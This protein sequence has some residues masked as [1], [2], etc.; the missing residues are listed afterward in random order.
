MTI[1]II[2]LLSFIARIYGFNPKI[3]CDP[4]KVFKQYAGNNLIE[5]EMRDTS[6]FKVKAVDRVIEGI[7][8][9]KPLF[10]I[11]AKQARSKMVERGSQIGVNWSTYRED[12]ESNMDKLM[13]DYDHLNQPNL[14]YPDYYLKPFHAYDE[15]NLSWRVRLIF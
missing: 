11:A 12:L 13:K 10:N 4:R 2:V 6:S 7:F 14:V 9:I 1:A 3:S 15:G 8:N 5:Q